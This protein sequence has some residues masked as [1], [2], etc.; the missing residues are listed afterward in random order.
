MADQNSDTNQ[1]TPVWQYVPFGEYNIPSASVEQ[2]VK[3][4]LL[5]LWKKLFPKSTK[6]EPSF[7][8]ED[9]LQTLSEDLLDRIAPPPEWNEAA[10]ALD[11]VLQEWL[12]KKAEE[13]PNVIVVGAP[14]SGNEQILCRWAEKHEWRIIAPPI[15]EEILAQDYS[16]LDQL[17]EDN[18]PWVFPH[19]EWCYLRHVH[20]LGLVRQLFHQLWTG[21]LGRGV[22]GCDSWAWVFLHQVWHD[23]PPMTFIAQAF[24]QER[25]AR[26]FYSLLSKSDRDQFVFRQTDN[27]KYVIGPPPDQVSPDS[28]DSESS[29]F[30]QR[31]AAHTRGNPGLAWTLWR[32]SL[33]SEPDEVPEKEAE[34]QKDSAQY[35]TI[36]VRPWDRI[37]RLSLPSGAGRDHAFVLHALLLHNGLPANLLSQLLPLSRPE[38]IQTLYSL[39]EADILEKKDGIWQ[40]TSL[41]YPAVR[42]FLDSEGY[43]T[44]D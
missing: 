33:R 19:L 22:I 44:D 12:E 8:D 15:P 32:Q 41:G 6:P 2:T 27:G 26:W 9:E 5:G 1:E 38:V 30:L 18:T 42:R 29:K 14:Y 3:T 11:K 34:E 7:R 31:L 4:N 10:T 23:R 40:V 21:Q 35:T 13:N 17:A 28:S 37:A 24:D 39:E 43:L 16:W 36:W 20:G 25:L